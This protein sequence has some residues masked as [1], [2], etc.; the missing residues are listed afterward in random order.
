M[1]TGGGNK[2]GTE[3]IT[4]LE[5]KVKQKLQKPKL[6]KVLFHNDDYTPMEFVVW[7]LMNIFQRSENEAMAIMLLAHRTGKAVAGVYTRD[8]AET[9]MAESQKAAEEME[10]PLLVTIEPDDFSDEEKDG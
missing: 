8:V 1:A 6:W 10:F 3:G 7:L 9:K 2:K 5:P 4:V